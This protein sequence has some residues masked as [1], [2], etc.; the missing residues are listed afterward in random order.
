[1]ASR[2]LFWEGA[3]INNA[4]V[5]L[6]AGG[7]GTDRGLG[8]PDAP[9]YDQ[10]AEVFG[11]SGGASVLRAAAVHDVGGMPAEFFLYYE[12]TDLSWRLRLAGWRIW[13][14]PQS[15]VW[16]RHG[17]S[18]DLSSDLFA[19]HTE[20][21][22]LLMLFRCAPL[23]FALTQVVRF[24]ITTVSLQTRRTLG[25]NVGDARVFGLGLRLRVLRSVLG[26]L[27]RALRVRKTAGGYGRL[28]RRAAVQDW[29]PR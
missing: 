11:F 17:A 23:R 2:M 21:N 20:R 5:D 15:L 6:V 7:Y 28:A 29:L 22:R 12:D 27:P 10:P 4:G 25:Q 14:E 13:Y 26:H 1:V 24:G 9:P 19:F 3:T 16:H 8:E 18:S